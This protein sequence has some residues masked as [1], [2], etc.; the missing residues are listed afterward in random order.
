MS[1]HFGPNFFQLRPQFSFM[2]KQRL[3]I[4]P[5]NVGLC[6]LL[7]SHST[8]NECPGIWRQSR[9]PLGDHFR[10]PVAHT[11]LT[12]KSQWPY[13]IVSRSIVEYALRCDRFYRTSK[14]TVMFGLDS[15]HMESLLG[16]DN[17]EIIISPCA[18]A[19]QDNVVTRQRAITTLYV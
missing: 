13:G 12:Q 3:F 4:G 10:S 1:D 6:S 15:M 11:R 7:R 14:T 17:D 16:I 9:C 2:V 8:G 19:P 5:D 18:T